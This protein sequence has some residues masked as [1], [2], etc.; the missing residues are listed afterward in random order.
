MK[1]QFILG[2]FV[3]ILLGLLL[4]ASP[5]S[6]LKAAN[7][8]KAAAVS[9]SVPSGAE[10]IQKPAVGPLNAAKQMSQA[11]VEVSRNVTPS[12][13][14]IVN[15]EKLENSIGDD[16]FQ[17][18]FGDDF[19][20]FFGFSPRQREQV[21]KTLGSGVII[22]SDGY[23][24]TNNHVVDNSTKLMVTLPDGKR[25]TGTIVGKDPKTDLALV[26]VESKNLRP[27]RFAK[28]ENIEV[29]EW[30]L[31]FGSPFGESLQHSVTAGIISAKGRT[32]F[33]LADYEDFLQTDAAINPG[34]SGGALVDLD[35]NLLGINTAILS[36]S[37]ASAG[38][39]LA[40]PVNMVQ[41][42][43]DQL[44]SSGRVVRGY[45]GVNIQDVSPEMQKSL[46]LGNTDGAV[47]SDV[48]PDS[49]AAEAGLKSYDVIVSVN[50]IA[51]HSNTE[52]R[53]LVAALKPKTEAQFGII[54][55]GKEKTIE[56][57]IGEMKN[58][59][60]AAGP[61]SKDHEE[62]LGME[63]QNLTPSLSRKLDTDRTSGVVV[64]RVLNGS[65]AEEAGLQEGDV[66]FEVNRREVTSVRELQN[67]IDSTENSSVLLAVERRGQSFFV[68][69]DL[70]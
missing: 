37:G 22:S 43:V 67:L 9:A 3:A 33:G 41:S 19:H 10:A 1:K 26:K 35:G 24:V 58:D 30:V 45:L 34:N 54:R 17:R 20:N 46:N 18:Y 4:A 6:P 12:I 29:G 36:A 13:V 53:N 8:S 70:K 63:L 15:Q 65:I 59:D 38:V 31:A 56:V 51:V 7:I 66:I 49:P 68:T 21:Q 11:F 52:V 42:V 5:F 47:I 44:K 27:I 69:L 64:T 57:E 55:D 28:Y 32:N 62:K 39:G 16:A 61:Q 50:G 14:M 60:V 2:M 23:I 25:V 48:Q 40:I